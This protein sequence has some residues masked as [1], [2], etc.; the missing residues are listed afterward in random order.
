MRCHVAANFL[1]VPTTSLLV[2]TKPES[3]RTVAPDNLLDLLSVTPAAVSS[4]RT[5]R[6]FLNHS[7]RQKKLAAAPGLDSQRSLAS[8]R[9]T[10]AG[11][12]SRARLELARLSGCFCHAPPLAMRLKHQIPV[13]P[14]CLAERRRFCWSKTKHR[15]D[16]LLDPFWNGWAIQFSKLKR[17]SRPW[18]FGTNRATT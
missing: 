3:A 14:R 13:M 16:G 5:C 2:K 11:S 15:F 10:T 7:T 6:G 18:L 17:A 8:S 9:S 12:R 1:S 4:R